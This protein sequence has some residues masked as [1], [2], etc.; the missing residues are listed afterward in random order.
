MKFI[1]VGSNCG[2]D[3]FYNYLKNNNTKVERG[4]LVECFTPHIESLKKC[5][6]EF[7]NIEIENVA[8]KPP[9]IEENDLT[10]YYNNKDG[11]KYQCASLSIEHVI[12]HGQYFPDSKILSCEVP[13]ITLENLFEKNNIK[14]LDWLLLDIEGI[15][16]EVLL[17]F[18]FMKYNIKRIEFEFKHLG[19]YTNAV[20][21]M[22]KGMGYVQVDSLQP[23]YDW[24]FEKV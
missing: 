6:S 13:C 16:A 19:Y 18:D 14:S 7:D 1:Q 17:T 2:Y 10:F 15:D 21:M 8:I 12:K 20:V 4:I 5:Y 3:D 11:P 22:M 23:I 24:A 9:F